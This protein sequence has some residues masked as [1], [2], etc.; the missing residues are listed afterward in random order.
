MRPS[1]R[2]LPST[3]PVGT[4]SVPGTRV[5]VVEAREVAIPGT[6][7]TRP[8][9][10]CELKNRNESN[11]T[12]VDNGRQGD[13]CRPGPP[14]R[15]PARPALFRR[16]GPSRRPRR[17]RRTSSAF[18]WCSP[19]TERR[20]PRS[21]PSRRASRRRPAP[22]ATLR[23]F[24]SED[25]ASI[26]LGEFFPLS[27]SPEATRARLLAEEQPAPPAQSHLHDHRLHRLP[28]RALPRAHAADSRLRVVSHGGAMAIRYLPLVKIHDWAFAAAEAAAALANV[29]PASG[30][31][32]RSRDLSSRRRHDRQG[33]ARSRVRHRR[34]D[35]RAG[36]LSGRDLERTCPRPRRLRHQPR[37]E[38]RAQRNARLLLSRE[39]G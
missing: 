38:A 14:R 11:I 29:S 37:P 33:R 35:R 32:I 13:L 39:H 22:L 24:V 19:G 16:G 1:G 25:G 36:C 20:D 6:R 15:H 17:P 2:R 9:A 12:L 28:V 23:G 7:R 30:R 26:L 18:R 31:Q 21:C 34:V 5:T 10:S 4:R 3:S 8:S 27:E